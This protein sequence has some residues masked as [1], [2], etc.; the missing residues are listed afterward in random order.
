[1]TEKQA[2]ALCRILKEA[3]VFDMSRGA[4]KYEIKEYTVEEMENFLSVVLEVGMIEDEGTLAQVFGRDRVHLFIGKRGGI[5]YYVWTK[6]GKMV[7][8]QLSN[9]TLYGAMYDQ[10]YS[11]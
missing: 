9:T 7:K 3:E 4:G 10:K 6:S 5:T 1:M 11:V 8:R 2:R